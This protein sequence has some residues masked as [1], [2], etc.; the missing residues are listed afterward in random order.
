MVKRRAGVGPL[1][2]TSLSLLLF[3]LMIAADS[4]RMD[5]SSDVAEGQAEDDDDNIISLQV[6]WSVHE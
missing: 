3:V 1:M 4:S 6:S 5:S 2:L